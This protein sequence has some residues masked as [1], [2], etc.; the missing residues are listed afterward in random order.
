M[1]F[2]PAIPLSGYSGWIVFERT[3][4]RQLEIF[5]EDA[6][7]QRNIEYFKEHI[8]SAVTPSDLVQDRRLLSVALGAFGLG[9]EIDKKA[10][11]R[12]VLDDGTEQ[13][14]SFANRL[15][16]SRWREFAASFSYGN[17]GGAPIQST[18]FQSRI[19]RQ[20]IE[21]G[22]EE[23]V[24]EASTDVRLAMN[25]RREAA[26]IAD[27]ASADRVGWFQVMGQP[28]LRSVVEAA[29]GLP[30]S[31]GTLDLDQQKGIFERRA[32]QLF[33]EKSP[34]IFADPE[35]LDDMLR[36][37]FLQREIENGPSPSTPGAAALSVLST[38]MQTINLLLSNSR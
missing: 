29:L 8:R 36:R 4:A 19:I 21:I 33:G 6:Q 35:K 20:Y 24:G 15:N 38:S 22:F 5:K 12:R 17:L 37:F 9:E 25:F 23:R 16:D 31:I 3:E 34:A 2:I 13:N 27:S 32:E 10:L 1:M 11:I 26:K 14:D 7:T 28:P 30:A 18:A